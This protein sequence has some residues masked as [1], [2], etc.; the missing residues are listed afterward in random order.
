[1][2]ACLHD[3]GKDHKIGKKYM[4]VYLDSNKMENRNWM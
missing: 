2:E 4:E 3:M 1:M